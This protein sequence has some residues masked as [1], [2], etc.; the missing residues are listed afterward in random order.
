MTPSDAEIE[1]VVSAA[2]RVLLGRVTI[3][4]VSWQEASDYANKISAQVCRARE[5]HG[6]SAR[7]YIAPFAPP[8]DF[9]ISQQ[10]ANKIIPL[11]RARALAE[12]EDV[13]KRRH[14]YLSERARL[15][16]VAGYLPQIT[17]DLIT[18]RAS[19][20]AAILK[21]LRSLSNSQPPKDKAP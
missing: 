2:N 13:V 16:N 3:H 9:N 21:D 14:V 17:T 19:E 4:N 8:M 5:E 1:E 7:C 20:A 15:R 11:I 6:D 10:I 18:A 12:A